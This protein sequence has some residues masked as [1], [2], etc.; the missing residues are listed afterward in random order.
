MNQSV[1]LRE[2]IER[3]KERVGIEDVVGRRVQLSRRGQRLWGLC[4]FHTEKTP[5]FT[6]TPESGFF[7]C[8]GCG[9]GGDA[10]SFLQQIDGL[11]FWEALTVLAEEAGVELPK[12]GSTE[13]HNAPLREKAREALSLARSLYHQE[14]G[15]PAAAGARD[16]LEQRGVQAR[17]IQKFQLGWAPAEPGWLVQRLR[18]A[19]ISE[20]AMEEARLAY[21]P[22]G[23]RVLRDRF[24]DR[25]MFPICDRSKRTVGFSGRYLPGSRAEEKGMGKYINSPE[26]PLFPKRRLLYGIEHLQDGLRSAGE[27][28]RIILC[29]GNLDVVLMHQAGFESTLASLGTAFSEDHARTLARTRRSV[30]LLL[31]SDQAGRKAARKAAQ[32]LIREGVPT[33]V[34]DLPNGQDPAS[35]ISD[36]LLDELSQLLAKPWDILEWRLEAWVRS[37]DF[38]QPNVQ[39]R[40]A[41]EMAEWISSTPNPAL[42]AVWTR[43]VEDRLKLPAETLRRLS[44][45]AGAETPAAP[46]NPLDNPSPRKSAMEVLALNEREIVAA[47]LHDPSLYPRHRLQL[48]PLKLEDSTAKRVFAWIDKMRLEGDLFNLDG[49]LVEFNEPEFGKWLNQVRLSKPKD[50]GISL[51]HALKAHQWNLELLQREQRNSRISED[52]QPSDDDLTRLVRKIDLSAS[53]DR[54]H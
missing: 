3:I 30:I 37:E 26:G 48:E 35:M 22:E 46:G 53:A 27:N 18:K 54:H 6:V 34:T 9:E 28:G 50:S 49:A 4:P 16:Y 51:D 33:M 14:M 20:E 19:G 17:M 32:I 10:I 21:R 12:R 36:N 5:S 52:S 15:S 44:G 24:W 38:N 7:K 40:A 41:K 39:A 11:E 1:D 2:I 13:Q 25:L 43:I 29:E 47:L 45:R 42:Q 8:F 31:D 23:Q